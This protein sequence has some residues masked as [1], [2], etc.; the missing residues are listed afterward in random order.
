MVSR[1]LPCPGIMGSDNCVRHNL[2][3]PS[4]YHQGISHSLD[5]AIATSLGLAMVYSHETRTLAT[6]CSLLFLAYVSH[7]ILDVLGPDKRP[8]YSIPW[9]WPISDT[10][11]LAPF[12]IFPGVRHEK[13]TSTVVGDWF[14]AIFHPYNLWAIGVEA[15]VILPVIL[16]IMNLQ[17]Q[18]F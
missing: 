6:T 11:Y 15:M 9:F 12:Q 17:K 10:C 8:L 3:K 2:L 16:F 4:L 18:Q 5:F 14:F 1:N 7:L 13:S